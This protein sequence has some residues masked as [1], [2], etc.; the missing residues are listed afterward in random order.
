MQLRNAS[1]SDLYSQTGEN[2]LRHMILAKVLVG[3]PY[4]ARKGGDF[5]RPPDLPDGQ[6]H[7]DG[8]YDSVMGERRDQGGSV[9]HRS[10]G[11]QG[12]TRKQ[13]VA[14]VAGLV[15]LTVWSCRPIRDEFIIYHQHRA[16]PIAVISYKHRPSCKCNLCRRQE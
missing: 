5:S 6:A 7:G 4:I 1:K 2:G 12:V 16:V 15:A 14:P 9:D 11:L 8:L 10:L 13:L 3:Q